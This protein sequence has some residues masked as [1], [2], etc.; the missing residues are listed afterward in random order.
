MKDQTHLLKSRRFLPLFITQFFGA[1]NDNAFKNALLIWFTYDLAQKNGA[2]TQIIV[3]IAAGLFILPFFL[4][5]A[6]A[7]QF[8]DKFEK[9]KL[10]QKI[11]QVEVIL[12]ICCFIGFSMQSLNFLLVILFFMGCQS[13]FF[14]PLKYSLLP[15]H[16]K[17]DELVSGNG[18]IEAGT[19]ISILLG[20]IIGGLLIRVDH[21]VLIVSSIVIFFALVG[22]FSSRFIPKS[23]SDDPKLKINFNIFSQTIKII[24]YAR[25][26]KTVFLSIL[27][28]SWFWLI[29]IIFLTGF[30]LYAK[31]I[32]I[33]DE[34]IVT[35]FLSIFSI[36]IGIG[37]VMCNKLLKGEIKAKPVPIG[38]LGMS[39]S[40][41]FLFIFTIFH[42]EETADVINLFGLKSFFF[43]SSYGIFISLSLLSLSIFAGIYIVPLYAIMQHRANEK[44]LARII[45]ANN[46]TNAFF[47][48]MASLFMGVLFHF[49]FNINEIFLI[50]GL[51]NVPVIILIKKIIKKNN[52]KN[53]YKL[54]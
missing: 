16:L 36:G 3:T 1:F 54:N 10:I 22:Y 28:I 30:P 6:L 44:F 51:V 43:E 23:V 25:A 32:I 35:L 41:I 12:M 2:D 39:V 48:V 20:T 21:G 37:S 19:F 5:S 45:S 47:M 4:F 13:T 26:E 38:C 14:G 29:G 31:N 8:A 27:G 40:I 24:N 34:K 50:I 11:K 52:L 18:L 9:S 49:K 46:V 7:G 53:A 15:L 33:G 42:I 17:D